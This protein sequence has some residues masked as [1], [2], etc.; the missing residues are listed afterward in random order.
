MRCGE[1]A[2]AARRAACTRSGHSPSTA[3]SLIAPQLVEVEP[4]AVA[5]VGERRVDAAIADHVPAGGQRRA[6]HLGEVLGPVGG[7]DQRLGAVGEVGRRVGVVEDRRAAA[8]RSAVPP[9]SRVSTAPSAAARQRGLG[10]LAAALGT[11][12]GD[13]RRTGTAVTLRRGV[14]HPSGPP[15]SERSVRRER[16]APDRR[17]A[18]RRPSWRGGA[19]CAAA[20]FLAGGLFGAARL[21][22]APPLVGDRP[23][24]GPPA[25]RRPARAASSSRRSPLPIDALVSPSV[26]YTPKRAVLGDDRPLADRVVAE[27][28][29]RPLGAPCSGRRARNTLGWAR[30]RSASSRVTVSSCSSLSS[31]AVVLALLHVRPVA[32]VGGHDRL[33]VGRVDAERARQLQQLLGLVERDA[34]E[35]H[36]L[37]QARHLRLV[38]PGRRCVGRAP[39]HVRPVAAVLGEHRA[40][41]RARRSA[42][43]SSARRA[44]RAPRRAVSSSGARS[45]G[46]LAVSSPRLT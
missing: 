22:G 11:L 2:R 12:E 29:Q 14:P 43:R 41:R 28:A 15:A 39:L 18:W 46:T 31:D 32:A 36:R 44:A 33:A 8:R 26:T 34:L 7:R 25:A 1:H 24:G 3:Q 40:A 35:R 45:S 6:H 42:R 9:V 5:L 37:E 16:S 19:S 30:D 4:A 23:R 20:A 21:A 13:V 38:Q 10:A 17:L 27:L